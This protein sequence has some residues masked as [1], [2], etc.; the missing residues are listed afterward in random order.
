MPFEF[1]LLP[2]QVYHVSRESFLYLS[3]FYIGEIAPEDRPLV[4]VLE[5][6]QGCQCFSER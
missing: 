1:T 3:E 6:R 4:P 5:V 2:L